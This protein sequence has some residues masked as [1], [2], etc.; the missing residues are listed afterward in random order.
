[1]QNVYSL[2]Q[3]NLRATI[4]NAPGKDDFRHFKYYVKTIYIFLNVFLVGHFSKYTNLAFLN[5]KK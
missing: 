4:L 5:V 3:N 2:E 1:M